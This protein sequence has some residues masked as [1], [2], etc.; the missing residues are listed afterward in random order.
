MV[1]VV[2]V[3]PANDARL[4]EGSRVTVA[5]HACRRPRRRVHPLLIAVDVFVAALVAR[6]RRLSLARDD[7]FALMALVLLL[8]C[9]LDTETMPYYHAAL[10]LDLLAWDALVGERLPL[11]ALAAT[12]AAYILFDRLTPALIGGTASVLY[13]A[14][15]ALLAIVLARSLL[16]RRPRPA[17]AVALRPSL[18]A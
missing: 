5:G 9:T 6:V 18:S 2:A 11:R 3:P 16:A 15:T 4:V 14:S 8:R 1:V 12:A 10:L 7:A 17:V 13:G